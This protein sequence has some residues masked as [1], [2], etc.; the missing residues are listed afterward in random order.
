MRLDY[1]I[2]YLLDNIAQERVLL[3]R[4]ARYVL[5]L[6][7]LP[8]GFALAQ[9]AR[10]WFGLA[11]GAIGA[12]MLLAQIELLLRPI[13]SRARVMRHDLRFY[14][15]PEAAGEPPDLAPALGLLAPSAA[16]LVGSMALFLPPIL[17]SAPSWQR[18]L[19]LALGACAL[20]SI[21]QRLSQIVVMLGCLEAH[22]SLVRSQ[23][24]VSERDKQPTT[25]E[26]AVSGGDRW[27]PALA[28]GPFDR[29]RAG[30]LGNRR[31]EGLV[32]GRSEDGLLDPTISHVI[33]GLP[34]PALPLS[35]AARALLRVE[36]YLLLRDFPGKSDRDLLDALAGL[37]REAHQDELR[38]WLLPPV[39]GKLYLPVAANGALAQ[40]L[41]ATARRLG[42]DGG[43]SASLGTWLVRLPP[44]RSYAVAGR[45]IDA[46]VALRL[47]APGAVLPH[48]LT[49][50]G[51]LRSQSKL[52]SIVYLA[53]TPLLFAERHGSAQADERPFIMRGG[54]VLDDM[55]GRGRHAGPRT[56]FVDGFIF[57]ETRELSG[58]EH[59]AAHTINL[60]VKQVLAFG[61][62]ADA[63]P[64]ERRSLVERNA[65]LAHMRLCDHLHAFLV[66]YGLESALELEWLD[67]R[68]SE[69]WPLIRRMSDLKER[70]AAFLD[71]A[72][73]LRDTA[74]DEIENIAVGAT[75]VEHASRT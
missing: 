12:L 10:G 46:L 62:L 5:P 49:I 42:M 40:L 26:I 27:S 33:A 50:Q 14:L 9:M 37:A 41:G 13:Q 48:H 73:R 51:D 70:D 67:G 18:L 22:L 75:K 35:P 17:A 52:L 15:G 36:G 3:R 61:L 21:W 11:A 30:G 43:Y 8:I 58:V 31:V 24:S 59:R 25:H 53:A 47:P 56:D 7:L 68:W 72:Q 1:L 63:R 16:A 44:A 54:G 66:D 32:S 4:L 19:A 28:L 74:L 39:G 34:L 2:D 6:L 71:R 57:A 45:L 64:Y 38:H 55:G 23:L 29:P 69:I 65:A 20:W 60:R